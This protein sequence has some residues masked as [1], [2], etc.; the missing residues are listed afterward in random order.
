MAVLCVSRQF[1]CGAEDISRRIAHD[2]GYDYVDKA[3]LA[4]DL[5]SF[6]EDWKELLKDRAESCPTIW[7]RYDRGYRALISLVEAKIY[8]YASRDRVVIVGRGSHILLGGL[9]PVVRVR[10]F[11]PEWKRVEIIMKK[12]E[13]DKTTAEWLIRKV[14]HDKACYIQANYAKSLDDPKE[15]DLVFDTTAHSQSHMIAEIR[16]ALEHKD[17]IS[18]EHSWQRIRSLA[19]AALVKAKIAADPGLFIPT[20]EV[21]EQEGKLVLIGVVHNEKELKLAAEIAQAT[22]GS[23]PVINKLRFRIAGPI[24]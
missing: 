2:M 10:F 6:G 7:E 1:S 15:F 22:A 3:R 4:D 9:E 12:E 23:V 16:S 19:L 24:H 17:R 11:A 13:M 8:E 14:D 5:A 20:L 18:S 21:K